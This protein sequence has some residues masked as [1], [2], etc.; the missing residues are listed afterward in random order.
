L[1][2]HVEL[3]TGRLE[4]AKGLALAMVKMYMAVLGQFGGNISNMLE[5]ATAFNLL[6]WP[7]AHVEKLPLLSEV[8]STLVPWLVPPII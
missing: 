4:A 2:Q 8:L 1:Q 6:S 7:K 3:L 5:E